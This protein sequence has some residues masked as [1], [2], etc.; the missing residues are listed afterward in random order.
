MQSIRN[1]KHA[2]Q[3][4]QAQTGDVKNMYKQTASSLQ[5]ACPK[6]NGQLALKTGRYGKFYGCSNYPDCRYT[7]NVKGNQRSV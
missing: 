3:K 6:C 1:V 5:T 2:K 7:V 4:V